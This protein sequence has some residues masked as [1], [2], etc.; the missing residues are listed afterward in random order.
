MVFRDLFYGFFFCIRTPYGVRLCMYYIYIPHEC[1]PC[2]D[3]NKYCCR[4]DEK[5]DMSVSGIF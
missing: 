5:G 4:K 1:P 3:F 2:E